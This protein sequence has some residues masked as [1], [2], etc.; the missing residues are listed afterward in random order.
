MQTQGLRRR[1]QAVWRPGVGGGT[2]ECCGGLACVCVNE[3]YSQCHSEEG[4]TKTDGGATTVDSETC[5][6]E[7][8]PCGGRNWKGTTDCCGGVSRVYQ[9]EW[10]SHCISDEG[11]TTTDA[12]T[13]TTDAETGSASCVAQWRKC[14][15]KGYEGPTACCDGLT[16]SYQ[17]EWHSQC[18]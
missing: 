4:A 15:G 7:Y 11:A 6:P 8:G 16:C 18:L 1:I 12:E 17:N 9:N 2:T 13:G 14:G 10:Y 5:S 3:W